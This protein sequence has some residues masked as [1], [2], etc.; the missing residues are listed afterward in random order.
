M[1]VYLVA[2]ELRDDSSKENEAGIIDAIK[3]L[4]DGWWHY[5]PGIWIV[6][7]LSLNAV[8]ISEKLSPHFATNKSG[9]DNLLITKLSNERQGW[10]KKNAW[11]WFDKATF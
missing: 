7:S 2:Y 8:G 3:E 4:S 1:A 10:L 11:E 9:G 5:L 6:N